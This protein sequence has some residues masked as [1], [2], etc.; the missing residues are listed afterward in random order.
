MSSARFP[1][2]AADILRAILRTDPAWAT[3]LGEHS[4]DRFLPDFSPSGLTERAHV[5]TDALSA[6]DALEPSELDPQ[7]RVDLEILR[8]HCSAASWSLAERRPQ[9]WDPLRHLP[10]DAIY[11]LLA[12]DTGDPSDRAVSLAARLRGVPELLA[13]ARATLHDMPRV[14]VETAAV[15]TRGAIDL[16]G[17]DVDALL[18]R[19]PAAR[20]E[21]DAARS[22]AR[23]ALVEHEQWIQDQ[24]PQAHG[25]PRLGPERYAALLWFSL[26]TESGPDALLT[27]AESDLMA[28]EEHIAE[29]AS[30]VA[31]SP[32]RA[33]QV[34]EVLDRLAA[35]APVTDATIRGLCARHLRDLT[36]A[37]R[38]ADWMTV[39]DD[40]V[41]IIEM[42]ESRRGVAVAYCDP[43][44]PLETAAL[45]TFFAVSPTPADWTPQRVESFYREYNGHLLRDLAVHEGVPGHALQLAHARRFHGST[46]VRAALWNGPFVEG[47]AVY[48]EELVATRGEDADQ[49]A[50]QALRMQQ[51]KM[52]LRMTINAILDIRV[53]TRGMTE[54]EAV[55]LMV[56]RGHQEEGEAAGKW[57]RVQLTAG[58]L[59]TYYVGYR[60]TARIAADLAAAHPDW[61][62]RACHD[63][64]LAHGSPS[65]RH[66][67]DLVGLL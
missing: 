62:T 32:P 10:G 42:P 60:E 44:G 2:I 51:L 58:Q 34:R 45:P 3:S 11:T 9:S 39:Y 66:L 47:W 49:P 27:Q 14:H 33:G 15:Q 48:A 30:R 12:R 4:F 67:R 59:P 41:D 19:A 55:S 31:G 64:M 18:L 26:D 28:F 53:H 1:R 63:A 56:A 5:Y 43:P 25:D 38:A 20:E 13:T 29:T 8:Q 61:S 50:G 65:P 16:L 52:A 6:L 54:A 35:D 40:D 17:A 23:A 57:R 21:V 22:S 46:P 37:V 36:A 7:D 24:I